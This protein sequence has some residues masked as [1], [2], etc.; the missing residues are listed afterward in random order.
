MLMYVGVLDD[1]ICDWSIRLT[2][3]S[4]PGGHVT[5]QIEDVAGAAV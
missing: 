1:E 4:A 3:S 5:G 2:L